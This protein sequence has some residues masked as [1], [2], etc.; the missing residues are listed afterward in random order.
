[1]KPELRT[2]FYDLKNWRH[3]IFI[4]LDGTVM[5]IEPE[6][7]LAEMLKEEDFSD[8]ALKAD[9]RGDVWEPV[10]PSDEEEAP[11]DV[12]GELFGGTLDD[13]L[14]FEDALLMT[15]RYVV[16]MGSLD[17]G[18]VVTY[19]T[20]QEWACEHEPEE[21][22]EDFET[23]RRVV[24]AA[25]FHLRRLGADFREL[26]FDRED[27]ERFLERKGLPDNRAARAAWASGRGG[28]REGQ[29]P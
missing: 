20:A 24:D 13:E 2:A 26:P 19:R 6:E 4:S 28:R 8:V 5:R 3:G 10:N 1:M 29:R 22:E 7:G 16:M 12:V 14:A 11:G 15:F 23:V 17:G 27:Y 25:V 18:A 21:R 9:K